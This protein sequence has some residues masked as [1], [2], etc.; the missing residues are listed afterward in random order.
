M[1]MLPLGSI[2]PRRTSPG[3]LNP[4]ISRFMRFVP[5]LPQFAINIIK[6][7]VSPLYAIEPYCSFESGID[8]AFRS[9]AFA[10]L[11]RAR[12]R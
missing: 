7:A 8:G 4:V 2:K 11:H 6:F 5:A 12:F 1:V 9:P 3:N 10:S